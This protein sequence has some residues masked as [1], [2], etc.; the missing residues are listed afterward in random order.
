M[1]T[2]QALAHQINDTL[3]V[4]VT[5]H[6]AIFVFSLRKILPIP[7]LFEPIDYCAHEQTLRSLSIRLNHIT[8][9]D[10]LDARPTSEAEKEFL[11]ALLNYALALQDTINKLANISTNLCRKSLGKSVYRYPSYRADVREY[12]ASVEKYSTLG[13]QLNGLYAAI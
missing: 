5:V 13:V 7:W 12:D 6:D 1:S 2:S 9:M 8:G 10:F 3:S 4:Y 11:A